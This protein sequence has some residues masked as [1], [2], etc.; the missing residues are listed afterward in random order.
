MSP[1]V[2]YTGY[3]GRMAIQELLSITEQQQ[4]LIMSRSSADKIK[5]SA[6]DQGMITLTQDGIQKALQGLTTVDEVMAG[7][8]HYLIIA[9][10]GRFVVYG[11]QR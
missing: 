11:G 7:S 5:N 4:Q 2:G 3:R 8:Y 1:I 10:H 6:I 9:S